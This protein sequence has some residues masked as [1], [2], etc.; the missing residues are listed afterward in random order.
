MN[1][2]SYIFKA[3]K[4]KIVIYTASRAK[5]HFSVVSH[6]TGELIKWRAGANSARQLKNREPCTTLDGVFTPTN[7]MIVV[8]IVIYMS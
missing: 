2:T 5:Q 7:V 4:S 3:E 8:L 6:C 1:A